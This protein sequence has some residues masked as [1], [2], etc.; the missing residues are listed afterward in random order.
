M[1]LLLWTMPFSLS[2][3]A[4]KWG[5]NDNPKILSRVSSALQAVHK[6]TL[7]RKEGSRKMEHYTSHK[8]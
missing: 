3:S 8:Q 6:I 5:S 1:N 7:T 4:L 2:T